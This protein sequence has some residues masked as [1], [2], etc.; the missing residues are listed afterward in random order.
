MFISQKP[1]M[2]PV[3]NWKRKDKARPEIK[4]IFSEALH[5]GQVAMDRENESERKNQGKREKKRGG[6]G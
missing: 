5:S 2:F 6:G 1:L 4:T 3:K